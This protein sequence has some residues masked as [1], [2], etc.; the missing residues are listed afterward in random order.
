MRHL[1]TCLICVNA[2]FMPFDAY[3][4]A[5]YFTLRSGGQTFVTFLFDSCFT[6]VVCVPVAYCLSRFTNL[7][8]VPLFSICLSTYLIKC[9]VGAFMLKQGKWIQ[10]LTV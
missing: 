5:T 8:I 3:V 1:A 2:V 10:N 9:A 6:W 7:T 4:N